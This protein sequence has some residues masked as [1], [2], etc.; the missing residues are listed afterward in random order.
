MACPSRSKWT[1]CGYLAF[2]S[3]GLSQSVV[4]REDYIEFIWV[5]GVLVLE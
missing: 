3:L 1:P 4:V 5:N 2:V